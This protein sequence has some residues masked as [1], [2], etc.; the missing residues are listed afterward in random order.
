[1]MWKNIRVSILLLILAYV[2][3]DQWREHALLDWQRP[4]QVVL[5]P[6]NADQSPRVAQYLPTLQQTDFKIIEDYF[7]Q[8]GK[9][10]GLP[11]DRPFFIHLGTAV[12]SA[13]PAPPTTGSLL[14]VIRWSL[15]F[16]WYAW[17]HTPADDFKPDVRLFLLYHD[18]KL[19]PRLSHSTALEKG[20]IGRVN[21]FGSSKQHEQNMIV[22]AHELL[23][24]VGATDKYD[25]NNNQ[26]I[27]PM[28]LAD[29]QKSPLYP[30]HQAE[31]MGG[32][33]ALSPT[34]AKIPDRL[35][36]T[37]MNRLTAIEIGWITP[38]TP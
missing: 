31:L 1:M 17:Q 35:N 25:L 38:T 18:P 11:V 5:Y 10:Y 6:I 21:L 29:P 33:I 12:Q 23:H 14:D 4:L 22:I 26:P 32:R 2:A 19:T 16:R 15:A 30:Q 8:H 3:L 20:R 13:P 34:Q 24:T 7:R 9:A 37:V 27:N 28:G 36:Q